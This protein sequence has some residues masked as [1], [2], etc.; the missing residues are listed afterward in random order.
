[1]VLLHGLP[2]MRT[3][4]ATFVAA[5][6]LAVVARPAL[7]GETAPPVPYAAAAVTCA[8]ADRTPASVVLIDLRADNVSCAIAAA[9]AEDRVYLVAR[10]A[11]VASAAAQLAPGKVMVVGPASDAQ[12]VAE[13]SVISINAAAREASIWES[14]D[15][16]PSD[17]HPS[18]ALPLVAKRYGWRLVG[19]GPTS[20]ARKG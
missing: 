20:P 8:A 5:M 17:I 19:V 9:N 18:E 1:M 10:N 3:L 6:S 13:L 11:A 12:D 7:A 4:V 14:R 2:D 15:I 16:K